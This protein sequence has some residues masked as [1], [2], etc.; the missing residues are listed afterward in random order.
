MPSR[1]EHAISRVEHDTRSA[2]NR[3][4]PH[5]TRSIVRAGNRTIPGGVRQSWLW[6]GRGAVSCGSEGGCIDQSSAK[7]DVDE[8]RQASRAMASGVLMKECERSTFAVVLAWGFS[9]SDRL[10]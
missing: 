7:K 10:P 8:R 9:F 1:V 3:T 4:I 2:G 6:L 5:Y